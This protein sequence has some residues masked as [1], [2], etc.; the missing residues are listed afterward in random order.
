MWSFF[1]RFRAFPEYHEYQQS[2]YTLNASEKKMGQMIS[3][4]FYNL[5]GYNKMQKP[6]LH[7][8]IKKITDCGNRLGTCTKKSQQL[9]EPYIKKYD[10]IL[11]LQAEFSGWTNMRDSAKAIADKSQLEADKAKSYL[12]SVKNSGNEE[13]IRKAEF[14]FE[15]A[16]RKA[17]MDRSSFEDTSKR[18]QEA[19]KSFQKKFLDFYVDTTKSYL[20]QR[21]ENSN[22][23]SEI[24]KDFLAAVDT[25]EAYDDGRVATYKE[26]LATLESM[27]LE[28]AGEILPISD[29]P[30]D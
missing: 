16:N 30:S 20:Q 15:N 4:A 25:F 21:I 2:M 13:T 9:T 10:D 22:K 24:S 8:T 11:P 17:E 19:S 14:A 29:L 6:P 27:E 3:E 5:P 26:F 12:D 18:V 7:E 28:L 23:V 1:N